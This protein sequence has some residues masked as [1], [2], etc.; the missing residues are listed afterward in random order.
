ML[1]AKGKTIIMVEKDFGISLPI[2]ITGGI[3][4][5]DETIKLTLTKSDGTALIEP[6]IYTNIENNTFDLIF[7]QEESEKM[8]VGKYFYDIDWYKENVFLGNV[9]KHELFEVEGK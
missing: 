7:T 9:V 3:I 2:T 4:S 1:R 8:S 5:N 6:K